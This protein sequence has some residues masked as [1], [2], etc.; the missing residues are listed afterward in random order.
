VSAP[1]PADVA[2][3]FAPDGVHLN[4]AMFGLPPRAAWNALAAAARDWRV[5]RVSVSAWAP[6]LQQARA[7]LARLHGVG[8]DAVTL[9]T[10]VAALMA[11]L[12]GS[13]PVGARVLVPRDEF[14]SVVL[15]LRARAERGE[16]ELVSVPSAELAAA[17]AKGGAMVAL[18]VTQ[19]GWM[20]LRDLGADLLIGAGHK[21]LMAPHGTAFMISTP[22]ARERLVALASGWT[23]RADPAAPPWGNDQP[24][25][26]AG[27][28]FDQSP[29][30][31]AWVAQ[32]E[33]LAMVEALGLASIAR[34]DLGLAGRFAEAIGRPAP[35]TPFVTLPGDERVVAALERAGVR[36]TAR[37]GTVRLSFHL[38]NGV[39]DVD[40]AAAAVLGE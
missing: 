9:G 23:A 11:P 34:H 26:A 17:A 35:R 13:L 16:V 30:F 25:R 8:D 22:A 28:G 36:F 27:P 19:A 38:H 33:S 31:L 4:T 12:A 1:A 5:G 24:R 20:D 32:V 2:S 10:S 6:A 3:E 29:A 18:D 7:A 21:W 40:R 37:G 39:A 15:P 14:L